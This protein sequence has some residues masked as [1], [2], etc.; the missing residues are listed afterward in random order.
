VELTEA[1]LRN[2]GSS[3]RHRYENFSDI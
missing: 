2:L 3:W 1:G